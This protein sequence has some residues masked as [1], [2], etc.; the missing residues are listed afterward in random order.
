MCLEELVEAIADDDTDRLAIA[1][2][3]H[4]LP[5][6]HAAGIVD[7][8]P[9]RNEVVYIGDETVDELLATIDR[10]APAAAADD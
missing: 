2:H 9:E 5:Q 7:Y 10:H 4:H 3:H 6:L 1:L 8:Q